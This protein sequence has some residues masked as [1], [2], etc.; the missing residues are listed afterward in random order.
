MV[1]KKTMMLCVLFFLTTF[2]HA[3]IFL[4][5]F[6]EADT[7]TSGVENIG[8]VT[9]TSTCPSC[10]VG[11][12]FYTLGGVL[13][14]N[15]TN[16]PAL[17]ETTSLI[18]ISSCNYFEISFDVDGSGNFEPCGDGCT[19]T[20]W[21]A[22][23]YNIDN[24]GWQSPANSYFCP[25]PCA[26]LNIIY[27]VDGAVVGFNYGTGCIQ[28]GS[29]LQLRIS[30]QCWAASEFW[31][32]DN[33]T[34]DCTTGPT[35]NAGIDQ[36]ICAGSSTTLTATNPGGAT[37]AWDNGITDGVAF[38]PPNGATTYTVTATSGLCSAQD[39]VL[40]TTFS[41]PTFTLG[42]TNPTTCAAPFDGTITLSGLTPGQG[43]TLTYSNG[44]IVGPTA[45][46]AD[47]AGN[48]VLTGLAAG[49]Y[50]NFQLDQA[51]CVTTDASVI[52]LAN[53]AA[54]TVGA[55]VDQTVCQGQSVTLTASNPDGAVISWDNGVSDGVAFT[56]PVGNNSYTVSGNLAG[57]IGTDV[58]NVTV[59]NQAVA[60]VT[61]A[62]PFSMGSGNQTLAASPAGGTWSSNCGACINASTGVFNPAAAGVGTWSICYDAGTAPCD[63]QDCI[64]ITVT[65][66][67]A[68]NGTISSN[69]P[70]CFGLIDGSATINMTGQTGTMTFIITD[71]LGNQLNVLN[72]NTIN[73][74]GEGWY[75]FS[76]TDQ[77]PCTYIDSVEITEP[78]QLSIDLEVNNPPCYGVPGGSA[79][80]EN[81]SNYTGNFNAISYSWNPN[82]SGL[83]GI[84]EDTLL[85]IGAGSYVLTVNDENGCTNNFPFTL[86]YPD[87]LYLIQFE[88]KPAQCRINPNQNGNGQVVAAAA[89]GTPDYDYLWTNLT[90]GVTSTN[91]TWGGQN[92]GNYLM[93]VTDNNG[94][95]YTNTITLDSISPVADFDLSS[96]QFTAEWEGT[97][98]VEVTIVNTSYNFASSIDPL[99]DTTFFWNF[100]YNP[101][102]I[103]SE[104]LNDTYTI[105]YGQGGVYDICL[106]VINKNNCVD[107]LCIPIT[108]FD[109]LLFS[110]PNVFTP[111]GDGENDNYTFLYL[112]QAV[113]EFECTIFDRWGKEVIS[114]D[115]IND[116]WDGKN[117]LN[118]D[119]SEGVYFMM[120]TGKA[121]NGEVF[122]GQ[123]TIHLLGRE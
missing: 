67:C 78:G 50:T 84:G 94:C 99:S 56:P 106:A 92:P 21:V 73:N 30:V 80:V 52:N 10:V 9:W 28:G 45:L 61:P 15:D 97:A 12:Y 77:F 23:E 49:S 53:A 85:N 122:S 35:V 19:A 111:N 75:Y 120:Y 36:S 121:E 89:G 6:D 13:E 4:E 113:V 51:G 46:T 100:G 14:A 91:T 1:L 7:Q 32:F 70:T 117:K 18:D 76:V 48:I 3:Q 88:T 44:A 104:S 5:T 47:G 87:S 86:V 81:I 20:D 101:T 118:A 82:P 27:D 42:S 98:P 16:G 26:S 103:L 39:D 66:G 110:A 93:T 107:T 40:I 71:S 41:G 123:G 74:L 29:T 58:V 25:G 69:N 11:D 96:L 38:T 24:T 60:A 83:N 79:Y 57:C 59:L 8:G 34:V 63:D 90:T 43:Y 114:F 72:S 115:N 54:P 68:L 22:L 102:W 116:Q 109:P 31:R 33:V 64:N 17:W 105:T 37:I 119:C 2:I 62:G 65:A 95:I 55:G 108:I 112:A